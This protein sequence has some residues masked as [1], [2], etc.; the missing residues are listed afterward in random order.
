MY[1]IMKIEFSKIKEK[2]AVQIRQP[3]VIFMYLDLVFN[4]AM[5]DPRMPLMRFVFPVRLRTLSGN[6][7][8]FIKR[9]LVFRFLCCCG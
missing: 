3:E 6:A 8:V 5:P 4:P 7:Q 9:Q 1:F 2:K